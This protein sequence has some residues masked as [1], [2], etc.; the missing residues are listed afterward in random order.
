MDISVKC[1]LLLYYFICGCTF[2]FPMKILIKDPT[3][4]LT[5]DKKLRGP[6]C[7]LDFYPE[8]DVKANLAKLKGFPD[9]PLTDR[10]FAILAVAVTE[11]Q[12]HNYKPFAEKYIVQVVLQIHFIWKSFFIL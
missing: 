3:G 2:I 1:F 9:L 8:A 11:L 6:S 12:A 7:C 10:E 4:S 5:S